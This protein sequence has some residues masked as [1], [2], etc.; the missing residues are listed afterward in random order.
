MCV[1]MHLKLE[2]RED[3]RQ[4]QKGKERERSLIYWITSQVVQSA[5]QG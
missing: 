4:R 3:E 5:S 1:L 2:V